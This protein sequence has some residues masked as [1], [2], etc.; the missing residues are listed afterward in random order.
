MILTGVVLIIWVMEISNSI[1]AM[2][3]CISKL[4]KFLKWVLLVLNSPNSSKRL[5][6]LQPNFNNWHRRMLMAIM[7]L[8]SKI[9]NEWF[10]N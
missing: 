9:S 5:M 2:N 7:V 6:I 1:Q 8:M 3:K 10:Y 4:I